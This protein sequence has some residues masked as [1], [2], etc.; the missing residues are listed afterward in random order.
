M[1]DK[2]THPAPIFCDF[3][4]QSFADI[5]EVGGRAYAH[6][7]ST[8]ILILVM[9]IDDVFHVWIP[10]YI[11]TATSNWDV[12]QLWPHQLK[13]V[14]E[15]KLYRGINPPACMVDTRAPFVAH[16]AYGFDRYIWN[17]FLP[18]QTQWMDNLHLA[19]QSG[20]NGKLDALGKNLLGVG[21]DQA[22]K[23]L[24]KLTTGYP[25]I[26]SGDLL[27]F[28]RYA[29]ADVEILRRLWREFDSIKVEADVIEVHDTINQRGIKVDP[30]LLDAIERVGKYSVGEAIKDIE[31]LSDGKLHVDNIRSV[32]Q[33]HD[34]LRSWGVSITDDTGKPCLRKEVVQKFIDTPYVI[35]ENMVASREIPSHV[36]DVMRL[37]MKALRIT[38][39]KV[40]RAKGR[41]DVDGRIKD[42]FAYHNA[43]TG[44]WSSYGVNIHN[45][46][47]PN[48]FIR[49]KVESLLTEINFKEQDTKKLFDRIKARIPLRDGKPLCTIDDVLAALLRPSFIAEDGSTFCIADY[50]Q[51]EA[52]FVA[53][54]A[55]ENKMLNAFREGRDLYREF[56]AVMF[57]VQLKEVTSTQRQVA[58]S[59]VLGCGYGMGANKFRIYAANNGAD[60]NAAGVTAE[61]VID[62]FRD[63]YTK[64]AGWRPKRGDNFRVGGVWKDVDKAIK[65][66]VTTHVP[67]R[68]GRCTFHMRGKDLICELPSGR[69]MY[70]PNARIEDVIPPY[71]YS[72]N[73]PLVPK[74]TVVYD[75]EYSVRSLYGSLGVENISQASCR[76]LLATAMVELDSEGYRIVA[77]VHDECLIESKKELASATLARQVAVMSRV[78]RWAEGM[79][80][81]VEGY[82]CP[83]FAKVPFQDSIKLETGHAVTR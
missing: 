77:H 22:K 59:A 26:S 70:Y 11:P 17:R 8:R 33:V 36:I 63:T 83:R 32:Q 27:A 43:A 69:E 45:M 52:R 56:A 73:L 74:A 57:G 4:T 82:T 51:V 38:G 24:K 3:E 50:A 47:R 30:V 18:L 41:I 19:K 81:K 7:S 72:M 16:N 15:V 66:V 31:V 29:V 79:P 1:I 10:S 5:K 20:R 44:R 78:P 75:G 53:W 55:D 61:F 76:D 39:D 37:R 21:K 14:S 48:E 34:W 71:C 64:I 60:L 80:I 6:H 67:T 13:P 12:K 35:E 46:P 68:A 2:W 62:T 25:I 42:L 23:L 9:C 40:K 65:E 49:D 54:M 58:K 28:T